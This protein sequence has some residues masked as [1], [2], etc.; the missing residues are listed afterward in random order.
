MIVDWEKHIREAPVAVAGNAH[1]LV[2]CTAEGAVHAFDSG[3][4]AITHSV[5]CDGGLLGVA[6]A[7]SHPTAVLNGPF[8]SWLWSPLG[9][10]P[11]VM[12]VPDVWCAKA[13]WV[14]DDRFVVAAGRYVMTFDR[15]GKVLWRSERL[16]STATDVVWL[17]GRHRVAAA[18]YGGVQVMEPRARGTVTQM[19]FKGSLLA[20]AATP[21]GKWIV[22]G[23]QDASLQVFKPDDETRLEMQGYPNKIAAVAFDSAG[24]WLA[25]SGSSEIT[26]W[27]FRGAGPRGRAPVLCVS[28]VNSDE[29][30]CFT[31]HPSAP[32]LFIGWH[33]G[34]VTSHRVDAGIPGRPLV[35]ERVSLVEADP[36]D[37]LMCSEEQIV[38]A[39]RSG[40][41]LALKAGSLP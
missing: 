32:V 39:H 17:G 25:N 8:G 13:Q 14:N 28:E 40:R 18:S 1:L 36:V 26:V 6:L 30:V 21:Q 38:I 4:G 16:P 11:P 12:L 5:T 33:T 23:N 19:P 7:P 3:T 34:Q 29:P 9:S 24:A 22:S 27:D 20:L 10:A 2:L 37:C 31:W 15:E 35:G 41:I